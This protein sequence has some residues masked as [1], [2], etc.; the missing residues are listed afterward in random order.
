MPSPERLQP[1]LTLAVVAD[2][3]STQEKEHFQ[4]QKNDK[5]TA[6]PENFM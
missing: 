4:S 6:A 3:E 1:V 5:T 2:V